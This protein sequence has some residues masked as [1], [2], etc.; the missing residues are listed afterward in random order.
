M[1]HYSLLIIIIT[2]PPVLFFSYTH[3]FKISRIQIYFANFCCV[4]VKNSNDCLFKNHSNYII[5]V[6]TCIFS[7]FNVIL[8]S[9]LCSLY[10]ISCW[11]TVPSVFF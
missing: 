9:S 11:L 5:F 7:N 4:S 8:F 3:V 1:S 2:L 10:V 6:K